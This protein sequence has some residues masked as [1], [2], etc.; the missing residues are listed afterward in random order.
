MSEQAVDDVHVEEEST[1]VDD[2]QE[3]AVVVADE[4]K[5]PLW[6]RRSCR[7]YWEGG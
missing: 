4:E 7:V 3:N 2:V 5:Q 6:Q 1:V